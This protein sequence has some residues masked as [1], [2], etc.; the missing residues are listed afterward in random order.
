MHLC[1]SRMEARSGS[2]CHASGAEQT[3]HLTHPLHACTLPFPCRGSNAMHPGNRVSCMHFMLARLQ[4]GASGFSAHYT[5]MSVTQ[6][7]HTK[8]GQKLLELL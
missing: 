6:T 1:L 7:K 4:A 8:P 2:S 3:H 5:C